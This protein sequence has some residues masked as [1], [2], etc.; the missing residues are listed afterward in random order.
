MTARMRNGR[1]WIKFSDAFESGLVLNTQ[2]SR[3]AAFLF[4]VVEANVP[5]QL[6]TTTTAG[7][8]GVLW[9]QRHSPR[10]TVR[11]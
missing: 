4:E 11:V 2:E 6:A 3:V 8:L 5:V 10:A 7:I 1:I 9:L